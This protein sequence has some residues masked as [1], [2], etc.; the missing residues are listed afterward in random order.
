MNAETVVMLALLVLNVGLATW[1]FA[2]NRDTQAR[3]K[4][5]DAKYRVAVLAYP[6]VARKLE[7]A[8]ALARKMAHEIAIVRA[9]RVRWNL[10]G[11]TPVATDALD[12]LLA[13]AVVLGVVTAEEVEA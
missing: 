8:H 7:R 2:L 6:D 4:D 12:A 11:G 10:A 1:S 3:C 5:M 13:R 9:N